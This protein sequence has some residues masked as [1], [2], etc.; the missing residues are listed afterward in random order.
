VHVALRVTLVSLAAWMFASSARSDEESQRRYLLSRGDEN[1]AW[2]RTPHAT[3]DF[4]DPI[5]YPRLTK[6]REDIFLSIGCET[7]Q[8]LEFFQNEL[9]G[10]TGY[11]D[12]VS[13]LQRYMLHA[14]LRLTRYVRL[15]VLEMACFAAGRRG[16]EVRRVDGNPHYQPKERRVH[17]DA[18]LD[19]A[20]SV[21]AGEVAVEDRVSEVRSPTKTAVAADMS[22]SGGLGSSSVVGADPP[23]QALRAMKARRRQRINRFKFTPHATPQRLAVDDPARMKRAAETIPAQAARSGSSGTFAARSPDAPAC[24][25]RETSSIDRLDSSRRS[26]ESGV[27]PLR[28]S[29][30]IPARYRRVIS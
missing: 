15:F 11:V 7:R 6:R 30:A 9:W 20:D 25:G 24:A 27:D 22:A 12:N 8:Y 26:I 16:R 14:E 13:W 4:F 3:S 2:L 17:G 1:W 23:E 5:K 29:V 28:T 21:D 18:A 10:S 19:A